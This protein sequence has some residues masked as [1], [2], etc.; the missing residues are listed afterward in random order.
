[1]SREHEDLVSRLAEGADTRAAS[2]RT[3][4]HGAPQDQSGHE[5]LQEATAKRVGQGQ[6]EAQKQACQVCCLLCQRRF[7]SREALQRHED[8]SDMHA[9]NL[10]RHTLSMTERQQRQKQQQQEQQQQGRGWDH[11]SGSSNAREASTTNIP[12]P[13]HSSNSSTPGTESSGWASVNTAAPAPSMAC[14]KD[15]EEGRREDSVGDSGGSSMSSACLR[16]CHERERESGRPQQQQQQQQTR[17]T[18]SFS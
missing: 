11:S 12:I 13:R 3:F 16:A 8:K 18:W 9:Q 1:M 5:R 4:N 7:S 2:W 15:M 6:E 10:R 17:G 14:G